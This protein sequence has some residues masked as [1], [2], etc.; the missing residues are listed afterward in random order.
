[1]QSD[2]PARIPILDVHH[3]AFQKLYGNPPE[4]VSQGSRDLAP[5]NWSRGKVGLWAKIMEG[6]EHEEGI[7]TGADHQEV[8]GSGG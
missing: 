6:G 2:E 4:L 8:E 5:E 3:S 7:H 1:M